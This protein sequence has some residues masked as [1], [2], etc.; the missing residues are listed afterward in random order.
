MPAGDCEPSSA[1]PI[2]LSP[3]GLGEPVV[4]KVAPSPAS[5]AN[6]PHV[7]VSGTGGVPNLP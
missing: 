2:L 6:I 1:V 3:E 4:G 5:A 7:M